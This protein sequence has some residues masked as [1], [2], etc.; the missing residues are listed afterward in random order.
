V[1]A[2]PPALA[3]GP[4]APRLAAAAAAADA[5]GAA[6]VRLRHGP[7][8]AREEGAQLKTGV[9]VAAEG[10][11]LGLLRT[12]F[13]DDAFLSEEAFDAAGDAWDP[14]AAFWTVDALDGTR[15]F[16]DGYPGF[17]VQM[18]YV[19][20]GVPR[21]GVIAEPVTGAC[22]LAAEGGG[23]WRV[24]DG[25]AQRL[26]VAAGD[27]RAP[28]FVDSTR[29]AGPAG[30]LFAGWGCDFLE[31]GSVGLKVCRVAEGAADVFAKWFTFKLWD[32]A[33]GEVLLREAGGRLGLWSGE[34]VPYH[35]PRVRF[36][37]VLAAPPE[38]FARAAAALA[39]FAE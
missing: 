14:P 32:V 15:S 26:R 17:C 29:P 39:P 36:T 21:L 12:E 28:V 19:V 2:L 20:D 18:A 5:A 6:L 3:E 10:W 30:A 35:T 34:P 7:V 37:G 8:R 9:D 38:R 4:W 11:V 16:V 33:P 13:P 1:I 24:G 22:Y 25:G 27:G 23:A 31:C